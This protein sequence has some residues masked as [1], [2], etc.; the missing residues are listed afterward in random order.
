MSRT[1]KGSKGPG[2]DFWGRRVKIACCGF[3]P[4]V[5]LMTHKIERRRANVSLQKGAEMVSREA[6]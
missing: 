2:Y 4:Y 1:K 3:G 6:F 5:K